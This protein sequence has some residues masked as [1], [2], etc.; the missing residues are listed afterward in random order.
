[1]GKTHDQKLALVRQAAWPRAFHASSSV[2]VGKKH[3]GTLRTR[4]MQAIGL[5][6]PGAS[7]ILQ[8]ACEP[9]GTDPGVY[10]IM[11]TIRDFRDLGTGA[12]QISRLHDIAKG[13][14]FASHGSI[15]EVL[16]QRLHQLGWQHVDGAVFSDE[17]GP[18]DVG[19]LNFPDLC[20]RVSLAWIKV[21]AQHVHHRTSFQAFRLVDLDATQAD[22]RRRDVLEQGILW[23]A[24]NGAQFCNQEAYHW[25]ATGQLSCV[26]C[27]ACDSAYHRYWSCPS[28]AD[29]RSRLDVEVLNAIPTLPEVA[30][31]HAWSL[32][33]S[34]T[35]DWAHYLSQL[36]PIQ[37]PQVARCPGLI[38]DLFVDGSCYWPEHAQFRVAAWSVVVAPTLAVSP[39]ASDCQVLQAQPVSGLSQT[40]YR[41]ELCGLVAA[42]MFVAQDP[43]WVRIWSDCESV[44]N[45][46]HLI[47]SCKVRIKVNGKHADLW[48]E[49]VRLVAIIG[50]KYIRVVK[51]PAHENIETAVTTFDE[52]VCVAN[53]VA[54]RAAKAA[55]RNRQGNFWTLWEHH[56]GQTLLVGTL[57]RSIRDHIAA[58]GMRWVEQY[59]QSDTTVVLP[60]RPQPREAR[61]PQKIW[62]FPDQV[63]LLG[64]RT[65]KQFG[66]RFAQETLAWIEGWVDQS[67]SER[68]QWISFAQLFILYQLEKG[69]IPVVKLHGRWSVVSETGFM[70][71][72]R[73]SF[74]Q[75]A[76]WFRL[77]LQSVL[78][79]AEVGYRTATLR[80]VSEYL[81]C[82]IGCISVKLKSV[83]HAL[84][85]TWLGAECSGPI[86][87][88][89]QGLDL[90]PP[91]KRAVE[92]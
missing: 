7:P 32:Q 58:V 61:N 8:L 79:D 88:L 37:I 22:V 3:V 68:I 72:E 83:K 33:P 82:H 74:R 81:Q 38:W 12:E 39:Q 25:S 92:V 20:K 89:G 26:A 62:Q 24:M 21:V 66:E 2:V 34:T 77:L 69:T 19:T 49:V 50:L 60:V 31:V 64:K 5:D 65:R 57:G 42:L 46:F 4:V 28:T 29:L 54:D 48:N 43:R 15:H 80:P 9:F 86:T 1:M 84:I 67:D 35:N 63:G 78:K 47:T 13:L 59:K 53:S 16:C 36:P 55:N 76:K 30:T 23:R 6:K 14:V 85:E 90:L 51:V 73:F 41:A 44:V 87:G 10:L 40:A 70:L 17:W 91:A 11:D 45:R 71:P 75:Q 52:W 27:G 18:F 56:V